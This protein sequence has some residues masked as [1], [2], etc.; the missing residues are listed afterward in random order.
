[1]QLTMLSELVWRF[2]LVKFA[3]HPGAVSSAASYNL[4]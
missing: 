2:G 4:S 1:M 3:W